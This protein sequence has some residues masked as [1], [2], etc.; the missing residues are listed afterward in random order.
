MCLCENWGTVVEGL[1]DFVVFEVLGLLVGLLLA[2]VY[3]WV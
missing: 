1:F 3:Y 2:P